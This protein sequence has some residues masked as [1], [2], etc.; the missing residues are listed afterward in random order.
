MAASIPILGGWIPTAAVAAAA[1][2]AATAAVRRLS[3]TRGVDSP[4]TLGGRVGAVLGVLSLGLWAVVQAV[5][6]PMAFSPVD[7]AFVFWVAL[8]GVCTAALTAGTTYLYTRFR[9]RAA[10]LSL[11][12]FTAFVWYAFLQVG[13]GVLTLS[14]WSFVYT[15]LFTVAAAVLVA[16][17]W[18]A[19]RHVDGEN[20]E[21]GTAA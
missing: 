16:A 20:G 21:N 12:A 17:E 13:D 14:I 18:L 6:D 15:P 9:Y 5:G 8:A 3:E 2:L 10:L 11:F 1:A 4:R 19:R 7:G